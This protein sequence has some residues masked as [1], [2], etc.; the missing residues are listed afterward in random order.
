MGTSNYVRWS[1]LGDTKVVDESSAP[2][3][4]GVVSEARRLSLAY[5]D[6]LILRGGLEP[7]F[8]KRLRR[9]RQALTSSPF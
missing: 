6:Q 1:F 8:A 3:A 7:G 5:L 4:V 9:L 2:N